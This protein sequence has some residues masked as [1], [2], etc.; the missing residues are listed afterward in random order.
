MNNK[1]SW[2]LM[3]DSINREDKDKLINFIN[4]T[5]VKFTNGNKVK[6]FE[7]AWS[8]WLGVKHSVFVNSGSSA[9]DITM[10]ALAE[11]HGKGE[12]ILPPLTW[13]S[14]ISSVIK[15]GHTPIFVDINDKSLALDTSKVIKA[16]NSNTKAVFL[17]HVLGLNGL[18]QELIDILNQKNIPLIEDVCES[19]GTLF[20]GNKVGTFGLASN[21][22]FY[23]AHHMTTIEG[24]MIS[25]NDDKFYDISRMMR[26][27][28]LVRES[29]FQKTKSFYASEYPDLNEEFIFAFPA[30]NMRSTEL[31]A[32]LGISQLSKL[33]NNI[34]KRKE[35]FKVFLENLD[36]RIFQ[37]E[38]I[39]EGNSNYALILILREKSFE[40][41][42]KIENIFI[43]NK[44]EFR[45]GT[46]G[47]GNQLRQ[48]YLKDYLKSI[49]LN[50]FSVVE[51]I[52][53]YSWYVGNYPGLPESQILALCSSLKN[54]S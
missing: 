19:H 3:H 46:A 47:G 25:T 27:H 38:F 28:G 43:S 53:F 8:N 14:D 4:E 36:S 21:F 12:V 17:T 7:T 54:L 11:I 23:F 52:H 51:H 29:T 22:S 50:D 31:N 16:I 5:D 45:R 33:D 41:R 34:S 48:P 40:L 44:I 9:N 6:E 15:A 39:T 30:H 1:F 42:D 10:L 20:K 35:N 18:T 13:V 32:V 24:G 26:A 2:P 49:N 37:T